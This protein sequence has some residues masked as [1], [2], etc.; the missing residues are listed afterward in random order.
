VVRV[1]QNIASFRFRQPIGSGR[2]I[3]RSEDH[4][5]SQS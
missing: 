2:A 3:N 5:T 4:F 1:L